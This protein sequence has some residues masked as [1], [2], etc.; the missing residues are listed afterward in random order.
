MGFEP[1]GISFSNVGE[2][3]RA[4]GGWIFL[5]KIKREKKLGCCIVF[6]TTRTMT[7]EDSASLFG[8]SSLFSKPLEPS[9]QPL[10]PKKSVQVSNVTT[11]TL[12]S[13]RKIVLRKRIPENSDYDNNN[14]STNDKYF[15]I[16]IHRLMAKIK[17]DE[18]EK[19]ERT[20]E[21][22]SVGCLLSETYRPNIWT[23]LIGSEKQH[24]AMLKW[25]IN[26]NHV[27]FGNQLKKEDSENNNNNN[28]RIDSLG[29]PKRKVLMIHGPPGIGKTTVA[30]ILARQAGYEVLE[31]NASDERN[32]TVVDNNTNSEKKVSLLKTKIQNAVQSHRLNNSKKPVCIV[33]DEIDGASE[34]GLIRVLLEL[35]KND[36]RAL[37]RFQNEDGTK[38]SA[39]RKKKKN[40]PSLLQR[41]IIAICNDAYV[42]ALR[43]LRQC[44]ELIHYN[45][46][47]PSAVVTR[48]K[49]ICAAENIPVDTADLKEVTLAMDGDLRSCLNMLQFGMRRDK[50]NNNK[51]I[52][53]DTSLSL[54]Q[55]TNRVFHNDKDT[56]KYDETGL[57]L[58]LAHSYGDYDR[59]LGSL[60]T[61]YPDKKFFDDM[62]MKPGQAGEWTFFHEQINRHIWKN[63]NFHL[64]SY[65]GHSIVAFYNLFSSPLNGLSAA[66]ATKNNT[67]NNNIISDWEVYETRSRTT[68]FI[69]DYMTRLTTESRHMIN[70]QQFLLDI[71]PH[72]LQIVNCIPGDSI[73]KP[74]EKLR[75]DHT[76]KLMTDL[77]LWFK[78]D[79]LENTGTA[80]FRL[81]PP[82]EQ[83]VMFDQEDRQRAAIGSKYTVRATISELMMNGGA[84]AAGA[85]PA[86]VSSIATKRQ[87]EEDNDTD[88]K[89]HLPALKK[90]KDF[91]GREVV[92]PTTSNTTA[93]TEE[94]ETAEEKIWV[95]YVEGF[96]NAVRKDL[97][98][99]DF[100]K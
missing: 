29:R 9:A 78:K 37:N 81:D 85:A 46:C 47:P 75:L 23:D 36:E 42:P 86:V 49:Q 5:K 51:L 13:G 43:E 19:K 50:K 58:E 18:S 2:R 97:N 14:A 11:A 65:Q 7:F 3:A 33:A 25:L 41:P 39:N 1:H 72:L 74:A 96:S 88:S 24:R 30:H 76:A 63:Q 92:T 16:D 90:K 62:L 82:I 69:K 54:K 22:T 71:A 26:W 98:W 89:Q 32:A 59:L 44:S 34:S 67:S 31:I 66:D 17:N 70:N 10:E 94:T 55:T 64:A 87:R 60:F 4:H 6:L 100:W 28:T 38:R 52:T 93:T 12:Q 40:D 53:K 27:V 80:V 73:V 56:E 35:V 8:E 79:R 95:Q 77:K 20:E 48:L 91:F 15:G 84:S 83:I 45:K 99:F 57:I 68:Q 21:L 61:A